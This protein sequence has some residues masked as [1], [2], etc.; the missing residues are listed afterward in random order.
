[1]KNLNM[2][3]N[4]INIYINGESKKINAEKSIHL[5]LKELNLNKNNI[6]VE[7]KREIVNKSNYIS[8]LI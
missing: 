6:A 2:S 3:K 8:H 7:I 1:M 5:L 4:E